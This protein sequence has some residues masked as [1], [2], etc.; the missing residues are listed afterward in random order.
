MRH[1]LSPEQREIYRASY[2]ARTLPG[3]P[4]ELTQCRRISALTDLARLFSF[5]QQ[6]LV[7]LAEAIENVY[8]DVP[9]VIIEYRQL[10]T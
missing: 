3:M 4:E 5:V 1:E 10:L 6:V 9:I 7:L 8:K 2:T